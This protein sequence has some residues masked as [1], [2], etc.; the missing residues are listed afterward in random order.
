MHNGL[1]SGPAAWLAIGPTGHNLADQRPSRPGGSLRVALPSHSPTS[2]GPARPA[3]SIWPPQ[4]IRL[5]ATIT[6]DE[7]RFRLRR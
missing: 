5:T 4:D 6:L 3:E 7:T 1:L 2:N